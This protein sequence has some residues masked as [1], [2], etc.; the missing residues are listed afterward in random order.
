MAQLLSSKIVIQ[1]EEP[2]VRG[3]PSLPT[4]VLG[5]VG[6]AERGPIGTATR[7]TSFEEYVNTFGGFT[8]TSEMPLQVRQF[9]LLGGREAWIT[10]TVHYTDNQVP[11]TETSV[12]G[13]HTFLTAATGATAGSVT[14]TVAAPF[15]LEPGDDIDG[16]VDA[17]GSQTATFTATSPVSTATLTEPYVLSDGQTLTLDIDNTG[18][19]TVTFNTAEFVA[20]GAATALEVAAVINAETTGL[21]AD[22]TAGAPRI[23]A[24]SRGTAAE[25]EIIGGTAQAI[26]GFTI[27]TTNGTG[28]VADI[29]S[30]TFA[31]VKTILE[32]ALTNGSGVTVTQEGGGEVTVTSLTTGTGSSIQIEATSTADDEMG[33]DNAVHSGTS[34]AAVNTLTTDGKTGGAY[35]NNITITITAAT[36]GTA[37]EF[38][39]DVLVSTI[40]IEQFTNLTMDSALTNYVETIINDADEG[41]NL[42]AATDDA[43]GGT[44]TQRRPV[45]IAATALTGGNDGL[46]SLADS[47]FTGSPVGGTGIR[48][49]DTI[50]NITLLIIPDRATTTTQNAMLLFCETTR[51]NLIFAI[52]DPPAGLTTTTMETHRNSLSPGTV[53]AGGLYWPRIDIPNPN[54]TIF[55]LGD[56][57]TVPVSGSVAG[58]MANNDANTL[59]GT[60]TQPAGVINGVIAG[61]VGLE[62]EDV[63]KEANRDILFPIRVNPIVSK[64]GRGIFLDGARTLDGTG[65]FRSIGERRG[66]S[67]IEK[68]LQDGLEFA[69]NQN[70]TPTL[71]ATVSRTVRTLL[72][73]RMNRGAFASNDPATAFFIDV[74]D[75]LNPPSVVD[76]GQ[77][78][79]RIG[80]ATNRP[81]EF[82]ILLITKDTRAIEEELLA[83]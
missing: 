31:E 8:S 82:I 17:V 79:V 1:E 10:R 46:A 65:N 75:K 9:F 53:E 25:I 81:A 22:T 36:S 55:G 42:I 76:A 70:N 74:S 77:L 24:D 56:A 2:R 78:K 30:V 18:T 3:L 61:V 32:A 63:Q 7:V 54:T 33:F 19:Q 20:I 13:T 28:N 16:N 23:T 15:N 52:L 71:R 64:P 66:V 51:T 29:D 62:T 34:G 21:S 83:T 69:R 12:L 67:E 38:N 47:D 27:A 73:D 4:A 48:A 44:A 60:F 5:I 40:I 6:L 41:S 59:A 80:L 43:A 72:I 14:G 26:L 35:A 57:L 50:S 11:A 58:I 39:L 68:I 49:F 37:S 45:N